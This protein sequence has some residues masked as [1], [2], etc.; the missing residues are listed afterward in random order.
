[1]AV[2]SFPDPLAVTAGSD[3]SVWCGKTPNPCEPPYF[4]NSRHGALFTRWNCGFHVSREQ[5]GTMTDFFCLGRHIF[6]P[7]SCLHPGNIIMGK[8]KNSLHFVSNLSHYFCSEN[9]HSKCHIKNIWRTAFNLNYVQFKMKLQK[10]LLFL[11][12]ELKRAT[13]LKFVGTAAFEREVFFY[14]DH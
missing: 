12:F 11:L 13:G 5:R 6:R 8:G 14:W 9:V 4:I 2:Q 1:M 3:V 7:G 10:L